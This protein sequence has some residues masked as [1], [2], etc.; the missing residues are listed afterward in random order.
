ML[1]LLA[2]N[3]TAETAEFFTENIEFLC[4]LLG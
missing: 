3:L 4:Q 1:A 2:A